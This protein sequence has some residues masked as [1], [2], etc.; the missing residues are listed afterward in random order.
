VLRYSR[1]ASPAAFVRHGPPFQVLLV[2]PEQDAP[3]GERVV[4]SSVDGLY[5]PSKS[6][7][8]WCLPLRGTFP[9][10]NGLAR[11]ADAVRRKEA[12]DFAV[13]KRRR[14]ADRANDHRQ[15]AFGRTL[16]LPSLPE[17]DELE[18]KWCGRWARRNPELWASLLD[19]S[20]GNLAGVHEGAFVDRE[21]HVGLRVDAFERGVE[22]PK[23]VGTLT[24]G[25][26]KVAGTARVVP[27]KPLRCGAGEVVGSD[28]IRCR[29]T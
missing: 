27:L 19:C 4:E 22:V 1:D 12:A 26:S 17:T 15:V 16:R 8:V 5:P 3:C 28:F 11:A 9:V 18:P 6:P 23:V 20:Q 2:Q 10:E 25:R 24:A 7:V 29:L 13:L 14:R 21:L